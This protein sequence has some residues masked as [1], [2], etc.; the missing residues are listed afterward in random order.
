MAGFGS[1]IVAF[2][3]V[4]ALPATVALIMHATGRWDWTV[5]AMVLILSLPLYVAGR[6]DA[7]EP[8]RGD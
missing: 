8:S 1:Y 2:A 6:N 7:R 4:G 3:A 5:L